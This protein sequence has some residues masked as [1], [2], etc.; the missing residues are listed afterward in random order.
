MTIRSPLHH[1]HHHRLPP[2]SCPGLPGSHCSEHLAKNRRGISFAIVRRCDVLPEGV[3]D[4]E[5][6]SP[7]QVILQNVTRAQTKVRSRKDNVAGVNL[8]VFEHFQDG[9]DTYELAG[10]A[11]GGQQLAR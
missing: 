7:V 10:L 8:P 9:S 5:I 6:S 1:H 11:R 2:G 3:D 4:T